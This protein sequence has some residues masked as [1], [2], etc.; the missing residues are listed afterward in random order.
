MVNGKRYL[1]LVDTKKLE[2]DVIK[3]IFKLFTCYEI[4]YYR[5]PG[6]TILRYINRV[7]TA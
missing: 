4:A 7:N 5:F 3:L 2:N 6:N 1:V